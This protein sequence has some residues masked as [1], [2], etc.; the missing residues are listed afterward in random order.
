[1]DTYRL[2]EYVGSYEDVQALGLRVSK[3]SD[4]LFGCC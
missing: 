4:S 2:E 3:N 1:M